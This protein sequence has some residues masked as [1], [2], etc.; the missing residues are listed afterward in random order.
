MIQ[1]N[2]TCSRIIEIQS[3]EMV[4]RGRLINIEAIRKIKIFSFSNYEI[5]SISQSRNFLKQILLRRPL[6]IRL[7]YASTPLDIN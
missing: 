7:N 1:Q 6:R 2:E 4:A 5:K 3:S